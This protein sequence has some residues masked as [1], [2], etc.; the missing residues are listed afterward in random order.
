MV[1][2]VTSKPGTAFDGN[3]HQ[4]DVVIAINGDCSCGAPA[5]AQHCHLLFVEEK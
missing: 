4:E 1:K 2:R 3:D 5:N